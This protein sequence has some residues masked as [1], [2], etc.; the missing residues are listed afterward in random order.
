MSVQADIHVPTYIE[1]IYIYFD[2]F[3][4]FLPAYDFPFL[5]DVQKYMRI[6]AV[7]SVRVPFE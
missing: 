7:Y 6:C 4:H 2:R 1:Y 5:Y 3:P